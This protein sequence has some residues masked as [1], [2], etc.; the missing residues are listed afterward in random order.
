MEKEK[1]RGSESVS[2]PWRKGPW[3]KRIF[4]RGAVSEERRTHLCPS[5][6]G[7]WEDF[8]NR[9]RTA[10]N[11]G[12]EGGRK[13][14]TA[15]YCGISRQPVSWEEGQSRELHV[16]S[17]GKK[18]KKLNLEKVEEILTLRLSLLWLVER[19]EKVGGG[20]G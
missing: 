7:E 4:L 13:K 3:G 16:E 15:G 19:R 2:V 20:K 6:R 10:R 1:E 18:K 14:K 9:R 5:F 11:G 8:E 17:K 12:S